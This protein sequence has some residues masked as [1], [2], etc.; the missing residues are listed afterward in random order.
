[1]ENYIC[2]LLRNDTN[3]CNPSLDKDFGAQSMETDPSRRKVMVWEIE[4]TPADDVVR[5]II[6]HD[7]GGWREDVWLDV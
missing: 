4:R 7:V 5:P 6:H 2:V 3:Y 1:M